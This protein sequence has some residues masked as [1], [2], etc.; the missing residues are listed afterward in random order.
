[1]QSLPQLGLHASSLHTKPYVLSQRSKFNAECG[2]NTY[3]QFAVLI[4]QIQAPEDAR[5]VPPPL[6]QT[7]AAAPAQTA[8]DTANPTAPQS[9]VNT[10]AGGEPTLPTVTLPPTPTPTLPARP[11]VARFVFEHIRNDPSARMCK[12]DSISFRKSLVLKNVGRGDYVVLLDSR[13]PACH[14][15]INS[16]R[17]RRV[18]VHVDVGVTDIPRCPTWTHEWS[19]G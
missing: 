10:Q 5:P 6:A 12:S 17:L 4:G 1:M 15:F 11:T 18:A 16:A 9:S 2:P 14:R 19:H 3:Q 8:A 13:V 7:Q